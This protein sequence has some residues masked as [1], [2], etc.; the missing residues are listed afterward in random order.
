MAKKSDSKRSGISRREFLGTG[1]VAGAATILPGSSHAAAQEPGAETVAQNKVG[2]PSPEMMAR[3][4]GAATPPTSVLP[5][6]KRPGSDLMVQVLR[7]LGI[8]YVI[9]N[10]VRPSRACRSQLRTTARSRM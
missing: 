4:V 9:S 10:P 8:E 2:T 1:A 7:D 3:E 6:V 5:A